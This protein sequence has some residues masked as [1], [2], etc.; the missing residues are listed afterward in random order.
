MTRVV[1][2]WRAMH[3]WKELEKLIEKYLAP[4]PRKP[5]VTEVQSREGGARTAPAEKLPE[6]QNKVRF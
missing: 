3:I 6:K 1:F 2:G 5:K 4:V